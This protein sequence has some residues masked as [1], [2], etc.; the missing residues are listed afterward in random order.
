MPFSFH[1]NSCCFSKEDS[2]AQT[3]QWLIEAMGTWLHPTPIEIHRY[4]AA[5]KTKIY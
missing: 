3:S 5:A 2:V 1:R 4:S